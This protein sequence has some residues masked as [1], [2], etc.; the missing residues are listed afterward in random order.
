VPLD[1]TL[2]GQIG[3]YLSSNTDNTGGNATISITVTGG[4]I[5]GATVDAGGTGYEASASFNVII[6]SGGNGDG[7]VNVSTNGSGV[8]TTVNCVLFG[9]TGYSNTT[10]A[11]SSTLFYGQLHPLTA[12]SAITTGPTMASFIA[13]TPFVQPPTPLPVVISYS[14]IDVGWTFANLSDVLL[15]YAADGMT[16][17]QVAQGTIHSGRISFDVTGLTGSTTYKFASMIQPANGVLYI[18]ALVAAT[19]PANPFNPQAIPSLI[20]DYNPALGVYQNT[21]GTTPATVDGQNVENI[22]NQYGSGPA[23]IQGTS[24]PVLKLNVVNGKPVL[25]FTG[26]NPL[27]GTGGFP[28]G[29]PYT[30]IMVVVPRSAGVQ[31][32]FGGSSSLRSVQLNQQYPQITVDGSLLNISQ[33]P[34]SLNSAGI[35]L[36]QVIDSGTGLFG[37]II[38]NAANGGA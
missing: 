9:G 22:T 28:T 5:S 7:I 38:A 14:E 6:T 2:L 34:L 35:F 31:N 15:V 26:G 4:A 24:P 1:K 3:A 32:L 37:S 33:A 8:I 29:S 27:V 36:A 18:S 30:V 17:L 12:A 10:G 13:G 19:T 16:L 25:R 21:A 11:T 20:A 23:L